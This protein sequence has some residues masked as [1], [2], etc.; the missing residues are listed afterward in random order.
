[1]R[2]NRI[3]VAPKKDNLASLIKTRELLAGL[4]VVNT[5]AGHRKAVRALEYSPALRFDGHES[6]S[7]IGQV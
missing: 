7:F 5:G 1:M 3:S 6:R 4:G 2:I